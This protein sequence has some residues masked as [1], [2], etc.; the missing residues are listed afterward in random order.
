MESKTKNR[1]N[2]DFKKSIVWICYNKLNKKDKDM[3]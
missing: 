2:E 3:L 1:Y